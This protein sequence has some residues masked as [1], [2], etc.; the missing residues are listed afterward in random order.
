M[1][2]HKGVDPTEA[3]DGF[4]AVPKRDVATEALGNICRAC[5]WRPECQKA[6]TDLAKPHHRCMSAGVITADGRTVERSD[7]CSVVFKRK[8]GC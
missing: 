1:Q 4:Y 3:P 6:E 8:P 2:T 7:G 5:D